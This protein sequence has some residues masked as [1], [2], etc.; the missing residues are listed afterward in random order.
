M[1]HK[2]KSFRFLV[3]IISLILTSNIQSLANN[4]KLLKKPNWIIQKN[5]DINL[6]NI[7]SDSVGGYYYLLVDIQENISS[8]TLFCHYVI[9]L[10]TNS[11]VQEMSDI[12]ADYDP[13]YQKIHFHEINRFR[14]GE[15]TNEL[16]SHDIKVIQRET[17]MDRYL[18]DGELTAFV[19]LEDMREGDIIEY[20]YSIQGYNPIYKNNCFETVYLEY[21]D[22][23]KEIYRR[24]IV[25]KNKNFNIRYPSGNLQ[26]TIHE[27]L[28]N[29]EYIWCN[30]DVKANLYDNNTPSWFNNDLR[31]EISTLNNWNEVVKLVLPNYFVGESE[32]NKLKHQANL[33]FLQDTKD[34][35]YISIIRFVQ[36]KIRY[37]GFES[38]ISAY[39]PIQPAT[40][41]EKRYA[42]CKA[43]ALLLCSLLKI[44]NIDAFPVLVNSNKIEL[45]NEQIPSPN[46]FNHTI[47]QI[48]L[49]NSVF[50]VDPTLSNQGGNGENFFIPNYG[51]GLVLKDRSADLIQ[52][53][54]KTES[55]TRVKNSFKT[56]KI[57]GE[58]NY[59]VETE[60]IGSYANETRAS[61][62]SKS[63]D[64]IIKGYLKFYSKYY[65]N[66]RS[67]KP[68]IY[69]DNRERNVL[70]VKEEYVIDSMWVPVTEKSKKIHCDFGALIINSAVSIPSSSE[71]SMP[72]SL[73]FPTH[74]VEDTYI[75]LPEEW[76]ITEK[77]TH[78]TD[79]V[80]SFLYHSEY[81]NK[82]IHLNYEY[83]TFND[84]HPGTKFQ[85]FY[86]NHQKIS[87]NLFY[88]L[89]YTPAAAKNSA[90]SWLAIILFI[91]IT[92]VSSIIALKIYRHYNLPSYS[93]NNKEIGG[94][95]VIIAISL[96]I[97][98]L[99][100][101]YNLF[102]SNSYFSQGTWAAIYN[103]SVLNKPLFLLLSFEFLYNSI[104][105]VYLILLQF[106]FY[107]KR[108]ILPRLIIV[109]Y[110]INAI[111][112]I[113]EALI[114]FSLIPDNYTPEMRTESYT[115]IFK[116][117]IACCIWIPYFIYSKRV[118]E[119][120][121]KISN[122][123]EF[124]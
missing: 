80:F 51:Y 30:K 22:P 49:N 72:Y 29:K 70:I 120:F 10:L 109:L 124:E 79:S 98:C 53:E 123:S 52:I 48:N 16:L 34:S 37:L 61:L 55:I 47:V 7:S 64:E 66:I 114:G 57:G 105:L 102:F 35:I 83:Q 21:N 12:S 111:V 110:T 50:Y 33:I 94:W 78:I 101:F 89:T 113:F 68:I 87:D 91:V 81:D 85:E 96:G 1:A 8:Q 104:L 6:N 58:V 67:V 45:K 90:I 92:T 44:Y 42:D 27:S 63:T 43:K 69:T 2:N 38:G 3:L 13:S 62:Q 65:P 36:D 15:K 122:K 5:A 20:S 119:T 112:L 14:N 77:Q 46:A 107:N 82:K 106:L 84:Y 32:M 115:E 71:R 28:D 54:N 25:P 31:I 74:I 103:D 59:C 86:S 100:I 23:V 18:Y 76:S 60:Y 99:K 88:S 56:S 121:I 19:N 118:K 9:K 95:L 41:L 108:N 4:L 11:G 97:S 93:S 26:P 17:E 24:I 40:V 116:S 117:M 39:K 75:N 73:S